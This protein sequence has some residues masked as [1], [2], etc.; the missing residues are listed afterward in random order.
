MGKERI[1]FVSEEIKK[2]GLNWGYIFD[3]ELP[4]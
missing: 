3:G 1:V 4:I 2:L